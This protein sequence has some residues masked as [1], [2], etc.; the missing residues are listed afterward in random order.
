[1]SNSIVKGKNIDVSQIKISQPKVLDNGAKL[2]YV[3]YGG[4]RFNI[5]TPWMEVPWDLSCYSE[6]PF[7][8]YSCELSFKGMNEDP[9]LKLF[10]DKMLEVEERLVEAGVDNGTS[11]FKMPKNKINSEIIS[12][13]FG[14]IVKVSKDKTT[15]EPDGKYAPT[16]RLKV[17][18]R[19]NVWKPK[20]QSKDGPA[21]NINGDSPETPIQNIIVKN[22]KMKCIMSCVGL[23][24][25]SGNYMCQWELT[26]AEVDVPDSAGGGE[27]LPDSDDEDETSVSVSSAPTMLDDTDDDD[28]EEGEGEGEAA[29][30]PKKKIVKKKVVK[31]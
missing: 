19:D 15:G 28:E 23:W 3:N 5:Q 17:A 6:G 8:K 20:L 2:V 1:M 31:N 7:P 29:V 10:H 26:R 11:W 21:F 14:S 12:S 27:F 13:K 9:A 30:A 24:I 18:C 16:M 22:A 4:N 25:A